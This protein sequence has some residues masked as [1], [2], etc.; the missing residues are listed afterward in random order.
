MVTFLLFALLSI[1]DASAGEGSF[2]G[3]SLS[4]GF[5][6]PLW[7]DFH[8]QFEPD[9]S[10]AIGL[11]GLGIPIHS[12]SG[13]DGRYGVSALDVRARWH[14]WSGAFFL[15]MI[16]GGQSL[17]ANVQ[18]VFPVSGYG[19]ILGR[20]EAKV[21]SP[22]LTPHFGWLWIFQNGFT[23]GLELGWQFPLGAKTEIK[24]SSD[25]PLTEAVIQQ[26]QAT[27]EYQKAAND[28]A[29]IGNKFGKTPLPYF[30][31]LRIGWMF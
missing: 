27:P 19:N 7:L 8:H 28:V 4:A 11:G 18:Q 26:I 6:H 29:D 31:A 17:F 25:D 24:I 3:V 16:L 14:P 13:L 10:G 9:F 20:V 23:L 12:S 2:N 15:G 21:S 1:S 30:T 22:Y 5:P